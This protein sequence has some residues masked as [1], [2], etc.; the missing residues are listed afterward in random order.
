MNVQ[1]KKKKFIVWMAGRALL[2]STF[3][4]TM[5]VFAAMD[6]DS[7]EPVYKGSDLE[8]TWRGDTHKGQYSTWE[9]PDS[10]F[11]VPAEYSNSIKATAST[12]HSSF[13]TTC[14][15]SD[16]TD[17]WVK[18]HPNAEW[19]EI[20]DEVYA[21]DV[22]KNTKGQCG[23][24]FRN[25]TIYDDAVKDNVLVDIK[26]TITDWEDETSKTTNAH[27]ITI[28][29][30]PKSNL[31][32]VGLDQASMKWEFFRAGTNTP[33]NMKSNLTFDDVDAQQYLAFKPNNV[34]YQFVAENTR[35]YYQYEDGYNLYYNPD[36]TNYSNGDPRNAVGVAFEANTL[37]F[38][39]GTKNNG[40]LT[41][42]DYLG[43]LMRIRR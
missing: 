13:G 39:Y 10:G 38:I 6:V 23:V 20:K 14:A 30:D 31:N 25:A 12:T 18:D 4:S 17:A 26:V 28:Q 9:K 29:K 22:K 11:K 41:H 21:F 27:H 24:W 1:R 2:I 33:Y 36:K 19:T 37:Q 43:Y 16:V 42:Y 40:T 34:A 32:L 8:E 5:T 3:A 7:A 15:P 35:L